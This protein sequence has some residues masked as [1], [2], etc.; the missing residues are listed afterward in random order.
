MKKLRISAGRVITVMS[1][2]CT[3]KAKRRKQ[4]RAMVN[5]PWLAP[6]FRLTLRC[7]YNK[8]RSA[9]KEFRR[10]ALCA[11]TTQELGIACSWFRAYE[12]CE[13]AYNATVDRVIIPTVRAFQGN[14][15][16]AS[17]LRLAIVHFESKRSLDRCV[18]ADRERRLGG[19]RKCL[20]FD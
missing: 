9:H 6:S 11:E 15:K 18:D 3:S 19:V 20:V 1:S 12:R 16:Q 4:Y 13:D 2:L 7:V 17:W 10:R 14:L 8:M 5:C